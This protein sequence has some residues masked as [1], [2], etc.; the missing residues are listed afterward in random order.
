MASN[1]PREPASNQ[2]VGVHDPRPWGWDNGTGTLAPRLGRPRRRGAR[3]GYLQVVAAPRVG[4]LQDGIGRVEAGRLLGSALSLVRRESVWMEEAHQG[5]IV[6]ADPFRAPRSGSARAPGSGWHRAR[7]ARGGPGTRPR[8]SA[9]PVTNRALR[10][11]P[12]CARGPGQRQ[13]LLRGYRSSWAGPSP[14]R[15]DVRSSAAG[16][17]TPARRPGSSGAICRE[18]SSAGLGGQGG[19]GAAIAV[20]VV[21]IVAIPVTASSLTMLDQDRAQDVGAR[22]T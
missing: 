19:M 8:P 16:A 13:V 6:L 9:H 2:C 21:V 12:R 17:D 4:F 14:G 15:Q 3:H 10:R 7:T 5:A 22:G 1:T 18:S 11:S 20:R